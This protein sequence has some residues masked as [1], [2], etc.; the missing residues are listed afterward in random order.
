MISKP[1]VPKEGLSSGCSSLLPKEKV[2]EVGNLERSYPV[3]SFS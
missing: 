2:L 1:V 3:V